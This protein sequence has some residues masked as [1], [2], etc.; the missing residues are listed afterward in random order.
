[1]PSLTYWVGAWSGDWR[2]WTSA[3]SMKVGEEV[4][5]F[6]AAPIER[7]LVGACIGGFPE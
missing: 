3:L 6:M 2:M 1:M 7:G 5:K 4:A